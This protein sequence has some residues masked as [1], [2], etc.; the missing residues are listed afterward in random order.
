MWFCVRERV[1]VQIESKRGGLQTIEDRFVLVRARSHAAARTRALTEA[2]G[3]ARP[4]LNSDGL[5]VRWQL[6]AI[7]A[8]EHVYDSDLRPEGSEVFSERRERRM[9]KASAWHPR[10]SKRRRA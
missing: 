8:V 10:T 5:L 2:R 6:E 1:A 3:Y 4:Y 7:V 9:Q